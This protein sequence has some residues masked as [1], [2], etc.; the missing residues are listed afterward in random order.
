M[1]GDLETIMKT[2]ATAV[3]VS[4]LV[5]S[6]VSAELPHRL[7]DLRPAPAFDARAAGYDRID[8]PLARVLASE[9]PLEVARATGLEVQR[10][11][12][13]VQIV[14]EPDSIGRRRFG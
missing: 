11:H 9:D 5:A 7:G 14:V 8:T 3:L 6:P 13:G 12:L 10:G 2:L 1:A 4:F